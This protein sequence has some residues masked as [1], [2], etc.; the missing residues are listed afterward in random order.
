MPAGT[1][2]VF[3]LYDMQA[4]L[5]LNNQ[6]GVGTI[7]PPSP[8]GPAPYA[9]Q[10][11]AVPRTNLPPGQFTSPLFAVGPNSVVV[12]LGGQTW[13]GTITIPPPPSPRLNEDLWLYLA[14]AQMFLF[15]STGQLLQQSPLHKGFGRAPAKGGRPAAKKGGAKKAAAKKGAG[16]KGGVRR[17]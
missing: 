2:Y 1:V 4:S 12:N 8:S 15:D 9:P 16:K 11:L 6:G 7:P 13:V 5:I 14:Y 3:N 17:G 10:Q